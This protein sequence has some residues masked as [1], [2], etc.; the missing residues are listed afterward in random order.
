MEEHVTECNQSCGFL[1]KIKL[2]SFV[3]MGH[4]MRFPIMWYVRPAKPQIMFESVVLT[5]LKDSLRF[6]RVSAY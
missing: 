2:M 5:H 3:N 4:D 1:S 6:K